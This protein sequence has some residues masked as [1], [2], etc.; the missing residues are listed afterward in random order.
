MMKFADELMPG[1]LTPLTEAKMKEFCNHIKSN[2]DEDMDDNIVI[3]FSS[4]YF[5]QDSVDYW[6][7]GGAVVKIHSVGADER[8]WLYIKED[9]KL[10]AVIYIGGHTFDLR[11]F[12][13]FKQEDDGSERI[14]ELKSI[15]VAA[16]SKTCWNRCN[17]CN[18]IYEDI[19]RCNK[20]AFDLKDYALITHFSKGELLAHI[21]QGDSDYV[22][23]VKNGR[24]STFEIVKGAE[25][26]AVKSFITEIASSLNDESALTA[27]NGSKTNRPD[28]KEFD[29]LISEISKS[30]KDDTD[31]SQSEDTDAPP[32]VDKESKRRKKVEKVH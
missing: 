24:L 26:D 17:N 7:N 3:D 6:L 16:I 4:G 18:R 11:A 12:M 13:R 19:G 22:N 30:S 31:I 5:R 1:I 29:E 28:E 9:E 14:I 27:G 8:D 15:R 25:L 20:K 32:L 23:C 10:D 2:A 21:V